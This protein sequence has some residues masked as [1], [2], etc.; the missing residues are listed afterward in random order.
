L[1]YIP[2]VEVY[3]AGIASLKRRAEIL[4]KL[5][6]D[7]LDSADLPEPA[8]ATF[9]KQHAGKKRIPNYEEPMTPER[10]QAEYDRRVAA[11][12]EAKKTLKG[13]DLTPEERGIL[14]PDVWRERQRQHDLEMHALAAAN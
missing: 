7:K 5:P 12:A 13:M 11:Y 4:R 10:E 14:N 9:H 6:M 2:L 1:K 8:M 3:Q